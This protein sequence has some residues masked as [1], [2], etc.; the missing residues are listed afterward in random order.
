MRV[1]HEYVKSS[2]SN[3]F[4]ERGD[5]DDGE[6]FVGAGSGRAKCKY[7]VKVWADGR[8]TEVTERRRNLDEA[9][10]F[11]FD[12]GKRAWKKVKAKAMGKGRG[13]GK[14]EKRSEVGMRAE[15]ERLDK[16]E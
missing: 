16:C 14:K 13:N 1:S 11:L 10:D 7:S 12:K 5:F 2:G 9:V 4:V 3:V 6:M 8:D 15:E